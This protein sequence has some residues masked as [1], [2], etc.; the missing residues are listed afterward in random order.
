MTGSIKDRVAII[1]MG[2]T[3]FG[4]LWDKSRVDLIVDA[5]QEAYADA[6]IEQKR[7][8]DPDQSS[9]LFTE[10]AAGF[11][12]STKRKRFLGSSR[13]EYPCLPRFDHVQSPG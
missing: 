12:E 13:V 8:A 7:S 3:K 4:E 5:A 2:C 11:Q 10:I 1:G 9:F 6:G